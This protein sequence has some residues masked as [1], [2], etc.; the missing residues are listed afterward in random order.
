LGICLESR[1]RIGNMYV[2][3]RV[4]LRMYWYLYMKDHTVLTICFRG[5]VGKVIRGTPPMC[6]KFQLNG[7]F[8]SESCIY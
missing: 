5:N 1:I 6:S 8:P 4:S 3:L 7:V 2:F